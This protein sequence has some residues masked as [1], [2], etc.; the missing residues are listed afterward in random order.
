MVLDILHSKEGMDAFRQAVQSPDIKRALILSDTD[1]QKALEKALTEGENRSLLQQ[2]IQQ[3]QFAKALAD[4]V[5]EQNRQ[6]LKDLMKDP[7]YQQMMLDLLKTPDFQKQLLALMT[8]PVYRQQTMKVM[9]EA[10]QNPEFKLLFMDNLKQAVREIGPQ[11]RQGE[12]QGNRQGQDQQ[13]N[14]GQQ[15]RQEQD[16]QNQEKE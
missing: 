9:Q 11:S 13:G 1:M 6:L 12:Q 10:M 15:D 14:Q 3:P 2:Q 8:S 5:K 7:E 16:K 4:A